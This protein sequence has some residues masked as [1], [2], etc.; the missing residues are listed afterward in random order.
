M[1]ARL[2]AQEGFQPSKMRHF[3][4]V[5]PA[6]DCEFAAPSGMARSSVDPREAS[7]CWALQQSSNVTVAL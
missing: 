3:H 1:G 5:Q 2:K 4:A 6:R 7:L